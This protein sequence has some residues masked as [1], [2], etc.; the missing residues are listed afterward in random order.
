MDF[1][2]TLRLL[3][4]RGRGK[5]SHV[6]ASTD[7]KFTPDN[8]FW[9][10]LPTE[11][12]IYEIN[13]QKSPL[14]LKTD[15]PD[16]VAEYIRSVYEINT[17]EPEDMYCAVDGDIVIF[18][19][20]KITAHEANEIASDL[21]VTSVPMQMRPLYNKMPN[22][23]GNEPANFTL[24]E[25]P[26][27][28]FSSKNKVHVPIKKMI[29]DEFKSND[30]DVAIFL[31]MLDD[32]RAR[33]IN[34]WLDIGAALYGSEENKAAGLQKWK[35]FSARGPF[36]DLCEEKW[37]TFVD[38]HNTRE[39]I[40]YFVYKD[41]P[42]AYE[43]L[44]EEAKELAFETALERLT[45]DTVATLF[46][47][48]YPFEFLCSNYD[49]NIWY[50]YDGIRWRTGGK[51]GIMTKIKREFV[52][53]INIKRQELS[54][55]FAEQV[56]VDERKKINADISAVTSLIKKLESTPFQNHLLSSLRIEYVKRNFDRIKDTIPHF[57]AFE[58]V[59]VDVRSG[60]GNLREGKPEDFITKSSRISIEYDERCVNMARKYM[61]EV[62]TDPEK[63]NFM[64]RILSSLLY[65][66]NSD[67]IVVV[68]Y[69]LG[70]NSKS[71]FVKVI[72]SILGEYYGTTSTS[73]L[74]ERRS[75]SDGAN[76]GLIRITNKRTAVLQEPD[77]QDQIRT[78]TIKELTGDDTYTAR[79]VYESGAEGN[80]RIPTFIPFIVTN[81]KLKAYNT[82]QAF[83]NRVI[84][85]Q[86]ESRWV[87][88]GYPEEYDEQIKQKTFP[89]NRYFERTLPHI[90][91]GL[92]WIIVNEYDR[93][94]A[95]LD[96]PQSIREATKEL[97]ARN[98]IYK[99]FRQECIENTE[100]GT[101]KVKDVYDSFKNWYNEQGFPSAS[102]PG[103]RDFEEAF[104]TELKYDPKDGVWSGISMV[105]N[106]E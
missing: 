59:I 10:Q 45:P 24:P 93:Y 3:G 26:A 104:S 99:S 68:L 44:L 56:D 82:D 81:H 33:D 84:Q 37:E 62:F 63:R 51:L 29:P 87:E 77:A 103:L 2:K 14:W 101:A 76:P 40:E 70:Y 92:A 105:Y 55:H 49:K 20:C 19:F 48:C 72:N 67:K 12:T 22:S 75:K 41:D 35:T 47:L 106:N 65:A 97:Q 30:D 21:N 90:A 98:D 6:D 7:K 88:K 58:N 18:P 4:H 52:P 94:H 95:G 54:E 91:K 38:T 15:D 73:L 50:S 86:F 80:E 16:A 8:N 1:S 39:T 85:L 71:I 34:H 43:M 23:I 78:G 66:R 25:K 79:D 13:P 61:G 64:Y 9:N 69:G 5:G 17:D 36:K 11:H 102:R 96:I 57:T 60:E 46:K 74:T 27:L 89:M 28:L 100:N 83:W 32:K 42:A 53:Y 31:E